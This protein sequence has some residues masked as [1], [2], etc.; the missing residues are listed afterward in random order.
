MFTD[1]ITYTDFDG[2][3]RTEKI[4]FNLTKAE[5]LKLDAS[6]YSEYLQKVLDAG[7]NS[8]ILEAY[9]KFI[10]LG[11]GEKS[12]D[13]RRFVK[14]DEILQ[15]FKTS[16]IFDEFYFKLLSDPEYAINFMI[17]VL[18]DVGIPES[19]LRKMISDGMNENSN[20]EV[21]AE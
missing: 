2:N 6:N 20:E 16:L 13:G 9:E 21:L 11:Y 8:K 17:G 1:S 4:Y 14:S 5:A 3:E 7:D 18:P 10:D 12:E 19:Q 15:N